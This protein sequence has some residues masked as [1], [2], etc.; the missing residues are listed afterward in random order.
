MQHLHVDGIQ[1]KTKYLS[2]KRNSSNFEIQL[3]GSSTEE[4]SYWLGCEIIPNTWAHWLGAQVQFPR[5]WI[6]SFV[7]F[8]SWLLRFHIE[9]PITIHSTQ[10]KTCSKVGAS[11]CQDAGFRGENHLHQEFSEDVKSSSN[12]SRSLGLTSPLSGDSTVS[13]SRDGESLLLCHHVSTDME[14]QIKSDPSRS[15]CSSLNPFK[16]LLTWREF[17][18][19]KPRQCISLIPLLAFC[20][21]HY[22]QKLW[23][24]LTSIPLLLSLQ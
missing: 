21:P 16:I 22:F 9:C 19:D 24:D 17:E 11:T 7:C 2:I 12:Y 3:I 5:N 15:F 6:Q 4:T 8:T 1:L 14:F 13:I 10:I 20:V 23:R 18:F